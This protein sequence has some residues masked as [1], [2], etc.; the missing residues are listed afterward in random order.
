[1]N[2]I[3]HFK[4]FQLTTNQLIILVGGYI[5]LI[6]NMPFL[7]KTL[8]AITT[9][10]QYNLGF[11][12]SVPIF[13]FCLVTLIISTFSI[14]VMLKPMLVVLVILSSL[15]FY[16]TL[17]YG[18]VFDYGMI[19]N[20]V[21]TD[22]AEAFSYL[23]LYAIFFVLFVG[24]MPAI[25]ITLVNISNLSAGCELI[26]RIKLMIILIL[27]SAVIG[28]SFYSNYAAVG[29]NNRA[30]VNYIVPFKLIDSSIKYIKRN[31]LAPPL[32]FLILDKSP[33]LT[34]KSH[35]KKVTVLVVGETARSKSFS[36]NGYSRPTNKYTNMKNVVSFSN[37]HSCGTA[38]AVSVPCMFSRLSKSNYDKREAVYQQNL[39]DIVQ[40]A[41]TDVIW[42]DNNSSCKGVCKRVHTIYINT[43][44]KNTLC[45]GKYCFDEALLEPFKKKIAHLTHQN[46]LI[47]LHMIGSHGPTYYRRYPSEQAIFMPDCRRSDI[48]NCSKEALINTY[49]NTIAYTDFVLAEI[50]DELQGM[51]EEFDINTS[52]LYVSDHGESIGENGVYLHGLPYAFAPDEQTH[53][54]MLYWESSN[55]TETS[56]S[57]LQEMSSTKMSHDNI[58]DSLLSIVNVKSETY[59]VGLDIFHQ[60][61]PSVLTASVNNITPN[62]KVNE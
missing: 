61:E 22:S 13:L 35:V 54:P 2:L 24:I 45:D 39:L 17:T 26:Q 41:G 43:D 28:A 55:N 20:T 27:I 46:T 37:M 25:S 30:L 21:E 9:L 1:M 3:S 40:L 6:F 36:L 12:F 10:K 31:Y 8:H 4:K 58:F 62:K 56:T 50:I 53:I 52:M 42:V 5:T 47:V 57:C 14:R 23:N 60:C 18:I 19:Q 15:I 48:Q 44:K 29:R 49:D 16:A 7:N 34:N 59:N 11:L 51:S 33:T 32:D 38:T